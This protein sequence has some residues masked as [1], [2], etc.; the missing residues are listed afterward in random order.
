MNVHLGRQLTKRDNSI[1][2]LEA[3]F[4]EIISEQE[5]EERFKEIAR[6]ELDKR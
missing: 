2:R 6:R 3:A 5:A 4:H 1:S